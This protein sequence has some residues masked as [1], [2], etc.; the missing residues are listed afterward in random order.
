MASSQRGVRGAEERVNYQEFLR[1]K[2]IAHRAIGIDAEPSSWLFPFQRDL[3]IRSL[4]VGR[5]ALFEDCGL[6]KTPQQLDWARII[7]RELNRPILILAP[8]AV[9]LQTER[10]GQKFGIEVNVCRSQADVRAGVNIANYERLAAF[11]PRDFGGLVLDESSILKGDGPLRRSVQ[12]F[13]SSLEYLLACTATPAPN[14]HM[15]LGNHSEFVRSLSK[16]EM[17][18]SFFVHD[19]GDTSKWR[20]KGHAVAP[21][22]QWVSSWASVVRKPS[23]LG[24]ADEGFALPELTVHEHI[25]GQVVARDTLFGDEAQNLMDRRR[26]RKSSLED[27]VIRAAELASDGEQWL[28]WCDLNAE[29]DAIEK[30]IPGAVQIAGADDPDKKQ[31]ALIAFSEGKLRVLVTKPSIAGFGMNFQRCNR[32]AFVGLSDSWEQFYQAVRRCWRFGQRRPVQAHVIIGQAETAVLRNIQRKQRQAE[33]MA[34]QMV[35]LVVRAA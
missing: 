3:V 14:D 17:L 22:W 35:Q 25:V 8:L 31:E 29:G 5:F 33:E 24:Y 15:E 6:G 4:Q 27:R 2:T 19:G 30:A 11:S 23:D 18:A 21:F 26:A 9:S 16:A 10:E 7:N 1:S 20:L 13:S 32:M 28:L 34:E 12:D